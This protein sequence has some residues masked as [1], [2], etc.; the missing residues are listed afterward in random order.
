MDV[1]NTLFPD[2]GRARFLEQYWLGDQMLLEHAAL[3]RFA[4]LFDTPMLESASALLRAHGHQLTAT[5]RDTNAA[6]RHI[7]GLDPGQAN[8]LYEAGA[9][10]TAD[11]VERT[12]P[13]LSDW[14]HRLL[15]DLGVLPRF[16]VCTSFMARTGGGS[17]LHFDSKDI[18]V[19]HIAGIKRWR[20]AP[21]TMF[22]YPIKNLWPWGA[23]SKRTHLREQLPDT[24]EV[25]LRPGS[26]LFLP[27]NY[28]HATQ[29]VDDCLAFTV[30]VHRPAWLDVVKTMLH[31]HLIQ[32]PIWRKSIGSAWGTQNQRNSEKQTF[33]A[34]TQSLAQAVENLDFDA[35]IDQQQ[36]FMPWHSLCRVPSVSATLDTT[37][38]ESYLRIEDPVLELSTELDIDD[39]FIG[40]FDWILEQ[41]E[42][43][44]AEAVS[45]SCGLPAQAV[46][47]AIQML[48][49]SRVLQLGRA[50]LG[51]P[52][53]L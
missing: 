6:V 31:A 7:Y 9:T 36:T 10:V 49:Q 42:F 15:E 46:S 2:T 4:P 3:E 44:P 39:E 14:C 18:F 12:V 38:G 22:E 17:P 13:L 11:R 40:L 41:S 43:T 19:I 34:L 8:N 48:L 16:L 24:T 1:L 32:D 47:S 37:D 51:E 53:R 29:V 33:D 23:Q 28:W 45:H 30:G 27:R 52:V 21:N 20:I 50:E 5:V 25:E 26:V 35:F